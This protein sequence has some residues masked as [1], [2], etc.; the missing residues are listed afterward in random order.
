MKNLKKDFAFGTGSNAVQ[1]YVEQNRDQI[2]SALVV[3]ATF[4]DYS[5]VVDGIRQTTDLP[6]HDAS[7]TRVLGLSATDSDNAQAFQYSRSQLIPSFS[8]VYSSFDLRSLRNTVL[9]D[10]LS[11][12]GTGN[13][14]FALWQNQ[15]DQVISRIR[16]QQEIDFFLA[17]ATTASQSQ[18]G[19]FRSTGMVTASGTPVA[20]TSSNYK[21]EL[22]KLTDSI[23]N[24]AVTEDL[25][26]YCSLPVA[27]A[28]L[29]GMFNDGNR[30]IEP[31][32]TNGTFAFSHY[33]YSNIT[34]VGFAGL[35]AQTRVIMGPQNVVYAGQ[36]NYG[37]VDGSNVW[38][39]QDDN[40]LKYRFE[41]ASAQVI[42][43]PEYF[44]TNNL[45]LS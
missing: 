2:I 16:V 8:T 36:D 19:I 11:P 27:K 5:V 44:V 4:E 25:V 43:F 1:A 14:A 13:D 17:N 21:A 30:W 33:M 18:S 6:K 15:I 7:I 39:S 26:L 29:N 24:Q 40:R 38:F 37:T 28:I 34:I 10:S 23:P 41:W 32:V 3:P 12:S 35:G 22:A 42:Q 31:N 45:A 20:I 9:A